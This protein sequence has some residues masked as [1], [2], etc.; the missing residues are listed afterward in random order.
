MVQTTQAPE[1]TA[2]LQGF[3]EFV[4]ATMQ[5]WTVPGVAIAIVKDGE[6]MLSQG[7]GLRDVE[8]ALQAG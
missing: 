8:R 7:F 5:S 4:R 1:A 3:D 2:A 6:V